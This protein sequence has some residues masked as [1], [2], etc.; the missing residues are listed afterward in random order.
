MSATLVAALHRRA[1]DE[2]LA[3]ANAAAE[4]AS[5]MAQCCGERCT[6]GFAHISERPTY[7]RVHGWMLVQN[8]SEVV[9]DVRV[10]RAGVERVEYLRPRAEARYDGPAILCICAPDGESGS[11]T[12]VSVP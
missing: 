1:V 10:T 3:R 9:F 11:L 8:E 2:A 4:A 6:Y 7:L 5:A 12:A